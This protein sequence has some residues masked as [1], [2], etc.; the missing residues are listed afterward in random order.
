VFDGW[1]REK[2]GTTRPKNQLQSQVIISE[3][4]ESRINVGGA[5][6]RFVQLAI[7]PVEG[8]AKGAE[9]KSYAAICRHRLEARE[10]PPGKEVVN[11]TLTLGDGE[12]GVGS[13]WERRYGLFMPVRDFDWKTSDTDGEQ[14]RT[15]NLDDWDALFEGG[16]RQLARKVRGVESNHA[17]V[18]LRGGDK[19][20]RNVAARS[21]CA[22]KL[23][24]FLIFLQ[25]ILFA[26]FFR[27]RA[28]VLGRGNGV[29]KSSGLG[30]GGGQ[31]ADVD[32]FLI[33]RQ[34]AGAFSELDG[35]RSVAE[36]G[37]FAGGHQPDATPAELGARTDRPFGTSTMDLW[38]RRL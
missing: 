15:V 18:S 13:V 36:A 7:T 37:F 10:K 33:M 29:V 25:Q 1:P 12:L 30:I 23:Q 5:G 24:Q 26:G 6:E 22:V 11:V 34:S 32:G 3:R 20:I 21:V 16:G 8:W 4:V 28:G 31:R 19:F 27:Q 35:E 9:R 2:T 17:F 38:L 14:R